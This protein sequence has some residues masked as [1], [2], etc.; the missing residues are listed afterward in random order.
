M[1][2]IEHTIKT[3]VGNAFIRGV[4]GGERKRVSIAEMLATNAAIASWDNSTR[5]LDSSTAV[6]YV[7]FVWRQQILPF[8]IIANLD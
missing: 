7:R 2:K 6:D 8:Q 4:S 3:P 5:G 1:F